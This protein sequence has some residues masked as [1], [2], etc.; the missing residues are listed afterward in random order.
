[1]RSEPDF[2][3]ANHRAHVAA[4][5]APELLAATVAE[6][7]LGFLEVTPSFLEQ[8]LA[9]WLAA[10]LADCPLLLV[11]V[12]GEAVPAE[13][14]RRLQELP[15]TRCVNLYG[16][17]ECT[18]DALLAYGEG[19]RARWSAGPCTM[20]PR[21]CWTPGYG[22]CR[23]GWWGELYLGGAGLARGYRGRPDLT[24]ER[25]VADPFGPPGGRLYRTGDLVRWR[26]EGRLEYVGRADDQVKL[27]GFRVELGEVGSVLARQPGVA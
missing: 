16:P 20:V 7:D 14:W 12:G 27:R 4:R 18:V 23:R 9:A 10:G 15:A 19:S 25:F 21:T 5:A 26:P 17:T 1:V 8:V 13:L 24:A 11:G 3:E 2:L 22:C 6:R